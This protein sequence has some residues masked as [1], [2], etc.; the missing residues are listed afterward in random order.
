MGFKTV[1]IRYP[2]QKFSTW[3]LCNMGEIVPRNY[4]RKVA[5]LFLAGEMV[6]RD[7]GF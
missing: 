7:G 5:E 4:A 2:E 6:E 1:Y 3:V